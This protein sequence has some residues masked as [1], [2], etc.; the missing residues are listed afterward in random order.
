MP[1]TVRPDVRANLQA[2][3]PPEWARILAPLLSAFAPGPGGAALTMAPQPPPQTT[4]GTIGTLSPLA[5]LIPALMG[6]TRGSQTFGAPLMDAMRQYL[7]TRTLARMPPTSEIPV[8]PEALG[9]LRESI[10]GRRGTRVEAT[11]EEVM[12]ALRARASQ[13]GQGAQAF[14]PVD[15]PVGT[16]DMWGDPTG[17]TT[18]WPGLLPAGPREA[19]AS[20]PVLPDPSTQSFAVVSPERGVSP[21]AGFAPLQLGED[22]PV[23]RHGTIGEALSAARYYTSRREAVPQ[24]PV[25]TR[26][27]GWL[28]PLDEAEES[29]ALRTLLP[30]LY[31]R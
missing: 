29:D 28:A 14:A 5:L 9:G 21:Q 24:S 25:K 2:A 12:A 7:R 31:Q 23:S 15:V 16:K 1:V 3:N 18:T 22:L 8:A 11:P 27:S 10:M 30:W 26:G 6:K 17:E 19:P 4:A 20:Y 13:P